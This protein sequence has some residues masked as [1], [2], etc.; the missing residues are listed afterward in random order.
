MRILFLTSSTA[1]K[2]HISIGDK[3][4]LLSVGRLV[5]LKQFSLLIKVFATLAAN[6]NNW[7]LRIIGEGPLRQ[8]Y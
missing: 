7:S 6:N 2:K 3:R 8:V 5:N 4:R 1:A